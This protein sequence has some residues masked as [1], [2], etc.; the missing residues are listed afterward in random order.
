LNALHK[1][2]NPSAAAE[3]F[4][5]VP[6]LNP[7]HDMATLQLTKALDQGRKPEE[8]VPDEREM[9]EMA[10]AVALPAPEQPSWSH[11]LAVRIEEV[12]AGGSK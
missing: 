4:P 7:D 10:E 3:L 8:A 12:R 2:A 5:Q 1:Q 11:R 9:L 6:A